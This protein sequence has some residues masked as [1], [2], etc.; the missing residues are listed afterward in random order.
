M[1]SEKE[2]RNKLLKYTADSKNKIVVWA[3]PNGTAYQGNIIIKK[4]KNVLTKLLLIRRTIQFGTPGFPDYIGI[5][6]IKIT[7]NMVGKEFGI[8][9]GIECKS[10]GGKQSV[11]QKRM[12]AAI[13]MRGGK[14]II[15]RPEDEINRDI[16][17]IQRELE[18]G[19]QKDRV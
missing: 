7:K 8:F 14:Y 5:K 17:N 4:I 1:K 10:T 13:E 16:L 12:Q 18:A 9:L 19:E 11:K 3:T 15:I 6:K 2:A